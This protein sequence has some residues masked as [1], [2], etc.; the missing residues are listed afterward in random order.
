VKL[1]TNPKKTENE[2][3][4]HAIYH[5]HCE[6]IKLSIPASIIKVA[7]RAH[8][9]R[10]LL[11]DDQI[12]ELYLQLQ[13]QSFK[14]GNVPVKTGK[15]ILAIAEES[16]KALAKAIKKIQETEEF[17]I[18]IAQNL[19]AKTNDKIFINT[20]TIALLEVKQRAKEKEKM[21]KEIESELLAI[22]SKIREENDPVPF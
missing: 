5:I 22:E 6:I 21:M 10:T 17:I 19:S 2:A 12:Q 16:K 4:Y 18:P 1:V 7:D 9:L 14:D 11:I 20:L 13:D 15:K 3:E 8:N